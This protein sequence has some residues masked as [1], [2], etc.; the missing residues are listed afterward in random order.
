MS[1]FAE[2]T[3]RGQYLLVFRQHIPLQQSYYQLTLSKANSY[4]AFGVPSPYSSYRA[5]S[6]VSRQ[7]PINKSIIALFVI[8]RIFLKMYQ[9]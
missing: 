3:G 4:L 6:K 9:F 5:G 1:L 2:E 7:R 8:H